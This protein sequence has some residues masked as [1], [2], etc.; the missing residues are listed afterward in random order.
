MISRDT[1]SR[2]NDLHTAKEQDQDGLAR[3]ECAPTKGVAMRPN[4]LLEA[5]PR[6]TTIHF[7]LPEE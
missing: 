1:S 3:V 6:Y 2:F 4:P 7:R 5:L